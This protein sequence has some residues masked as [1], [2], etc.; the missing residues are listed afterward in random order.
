MI[1]VK[2]REKTEKHGSV[3]SNTPILTTEKKTPL[4]SKREDLASDEKKYF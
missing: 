2:Y 4:V 1:L 3:K